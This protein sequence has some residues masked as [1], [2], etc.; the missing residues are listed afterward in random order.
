MQS[1]LWT[2]LLVAAC[3]IAPRQYASAQ[4]STSIATGSIVGVIKDPTGAV[5]ADAH[6]ELHSTTGNFHEN[7]ASDR[8][9]HFS[10]VSV[11]AGEYELTVIA[12]G[13][14]S[15]VLRPLTVARG[16]E[17]TEDLS[18]KIAVE[19]ATVE[20]EGQDASSIAASSLK[21]QAS[22][23]S[24]SHNSADMLAGVPGV[25]LH[26][27]GELATI[28]FLRGL[29]DER[30]KITVDGMTV[31][32]ACPNHMNPTLSYVA[33]AQ[34]A[35]V[36]VL[37]GITPVS[38]GGDSLGGTISVETAMPAF[39][40][41]GSGLSESGTFTGF[42][43]SNGNNWGGSL[44]EG[45]ASEHFS[46]GY[47]GSF[48]T[49]D[50][51]SDGA[52]HKVTSTYAQS[53][54]HAVTL[55]AQ[56][57]HSY[58]VA[59]GSFHHVP[60]EGFVN[61]FMDLTHNNATSLNVRYRRT[62][63]AGSFDAHFY[64]QNTLHEMN[65]LSDKVAVDGV[66]SSMPMNTHGRDL[67]YLI[68]YEYA[69]SARHTFRA[70]N[71]LHHFRLD[72]W[73]PPVAGMAPMMGPNTF[74]N[75]NNGRR[76]RL[77][78]YAEFFSHWN[79]RW[80]TLIGLRND[81]VWSNAGDVQ[82]YSS[83]YAAD[84][85]AFNA[86]K[87]SRTD[88]NFDL[89]AL[90]RY[91]ASAHVALEFGYARKNRSPN[92]YERYT[93]S[94]NMMAAS[95][96]GWFGDGN[97]YYGN[98]ALKPETGNVVSG[99]LLLHSQSPKPW[100]VKLTPHVNFIHDYVD[101]DV[102][103]MSMMGMGTQLL[104]F[105]NHDA[106]IGG[107]DLSGFATLWSNN[108]AG[109]GRLSASGAWLHGTR[110]DSDTPLYQMMPLNLRL[111]FDDVAKGFSGGFGAEMVDSKSRLDPNRMELRTPGYALFNVHAAYKTK[112]VQG[113]FRLD[114]LANRLYELPL[115]GNNID[116]YSF[117]G[118]MT[119]VTGRGRSASINLAATF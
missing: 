35:Q 45:I 18:L 33:P 57:G 12:S 84:A 85:A 13:F 46:V 68:R 7:R 43:R 51:Y 30:T 60:F 91:E 50:D 52:G 100:E 72:D 108:S 26:G 44:N 49:T 2:A 78:T 27:N 75:I 55:A 98:V 65:F 117:T 97:M 87:H 21:V 69:L 119:P 70:G 103:S 38:L 47:V 116:I 95:M 28:P 113:G 77:G 96:I 6:V 42:Y 83:M 16:A 63:S 64:W 40:E 73:W 17:L 92:L 107:G 5:I 71:E 79:A 80:S 53:T 29:G 61:A 3:I 59:T 14:A 99:T 24:Q 20:V 93:W 114:N 23:S 110:T 48:T 1:K 112:Y 37:A 25:S 76:T 66:G 62:L 9:G 104:R 19:V 8:F 34:A 90:A 101:V 74:I 4:Q 109:A 86:E 56:Y 88:V 32:S 11:P 10:F 105:A 106:R 81:T 22:D 67:G 39:A 94:T 54:D 118:M 111:G 41:P 89:T 31:S 115:G 36:T 15:Q 58:F 82:G 102:A